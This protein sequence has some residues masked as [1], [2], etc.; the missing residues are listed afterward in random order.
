[1]GSVEASIA[2][3]AA[4]GQLF[5]DRHVDQPGAVHEF[6]RPLLR[7]L[8]AMTFFDEVSW[9]HLSASM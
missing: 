7:A 6:G 4:L 5:A 8:P 1:M 3:L 2:A 9:P